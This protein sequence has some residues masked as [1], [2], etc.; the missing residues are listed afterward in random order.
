MITA[1]NYV[2]SYS[3]SSLKT[4]YA[5]QHRHLLNINR[6]IFPR[7][8]FQQDSELFLYSLTQENY[9]IVVALDANKYMKLGRLARIF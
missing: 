3:A 6:D 1:C 2:N 9:S 8:A 4:V 7:K 5:Q